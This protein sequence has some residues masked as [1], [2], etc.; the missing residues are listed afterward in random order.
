M[1]PPCYTSI[2]NIIDTSFW[3][4]DFCL[5]LVTLQEVGEIYL[6][7]VTLRATII[8]ILSAP[9]QEQWRLE[10]DKKTVQITYIE[11]VASNR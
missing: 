10:A 9:S 6:S 1:L 4:V 3:T 11:T 2:Y 5:L 7:N 8:L